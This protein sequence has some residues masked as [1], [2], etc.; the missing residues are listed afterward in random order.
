MKTK[1]KNSEIADSNSDQAVFEIFKNRYINTKDAAAYLCV[2]VGR[3]W[4]MCS[5]GLVP[6]YKLGRS[7]RYKIQDLEN[8]LANSRRGPKYGN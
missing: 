1:L 8:F 3:L 4:N 2:S 5:N 6:F 7:N